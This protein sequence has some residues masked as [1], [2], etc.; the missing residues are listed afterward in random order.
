[1]IL[2]R[3]CGAQHARAFDGGYGLLHDGRWNTTGH[4]VTYCSTSP[5]LCVLEKLVH[6]EDPGLLPALV[7]IRYAV[8]DGVGVETISLAG[9]PE[10]WR[11]R[12]ILTQQRGDEWHRSLRAPLLRVPSAIVPLAGSPDA[13]V[14]INHRHPAAA[15]ITIAAAAPFALDMRLYHG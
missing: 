3:L 6:V 2:W 4:A 13:N 14:L 15:E 11:V 7:V 5:S 10:S 9:L 1:M 8:P 12:E